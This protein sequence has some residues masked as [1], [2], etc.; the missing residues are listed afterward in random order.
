MFDVLFFARNPGSGRGRNRN[1][2]K[3][4]PEQ[5]YDLDSLFEE[6]MFYCHRR[7]DEL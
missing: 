1:D 2:P 3:V 6:S 4:N 7:N 5:T